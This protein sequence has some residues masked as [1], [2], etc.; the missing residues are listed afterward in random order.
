MARTGDG[1]TLSRV[2]AVSRAISILRVFSAREPRLPLS[3]I[4]GRTSLDAGTVRRILITLRDE[5]IIRQ[6]N[7]TG[8]YELTLEV[9]R[10]ASAVPEGSGLKELAESTL[11]ALANET[12]ATTFLSIYRSG[13]AICLARFHGA[14]PV[15]V[16]WWSVGESLPINCGAAPKLLLA[17]AS[18]EEQEEVLAG[19]LTGLTSQSVTDPDVLR[20]MLAEIRQQGWALS[21]DDVALGLSAIAVPLDLG[22]QFGTATRA[23]AA[24]SVG[25][26]TPQLMQDGKV[27]CLDR[28]LESASALSEKIGN[29]SNL[30]LV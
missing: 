27:S 16:N 18:A 10:L 19:E 30:L 25:G 28:L 12:Q 24:I 29:S 4:A 17:Y 9:I 7:G 15:Q 8:H 1:S 22:P 11:T 14:A 21:H 20:P 2:R 13:V 23:V 26:L 3:E 5:G 6:D